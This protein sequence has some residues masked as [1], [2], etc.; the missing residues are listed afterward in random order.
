MGLICKTVIP[1]SRWGGQ[2]RTN[3]QEKDLRIKFERCL[4]GK[5]KNLWCGRSPTLIWITV[6]GHK[7][8]PNFN[9]DFEAICSRIRRL[10]KITARGNLGAVVAKGRV[11]EVCERWNW[12]EADGIKNTFD[13][14]RGRLDINDH[15]CCN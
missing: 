8:N 13:T 5:N 6:F 1:I 10:R 3:N 15:L 4:I 9:A 11:P 2:W 14:P 12:K 7:A